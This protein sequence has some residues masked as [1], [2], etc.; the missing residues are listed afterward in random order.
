MSAEILPLR[1]GHSTLRRK[2]IT[3]RAHSRLAGRF[4]VV[5]AGAGWD[6]NR[7]WTCSDFSTAVRKAAELRWLYPDAIVDVDNEVR[8]CA[9]R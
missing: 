6:R 4:V 7:M 9:A 5:A 2:V 1:V 3:V 8:A